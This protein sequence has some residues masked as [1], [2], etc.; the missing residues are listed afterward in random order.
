MTCCSSLLLLLQRSV[1][2]AQTSLPTVIR[3]NGPGGRGFIQHRFLS[4]VVRD[5]R[6]DSIFEKLSVLRSSTTHFCTKAPTEDE[7]PP[8]PDYQSD[9]D[10]QRKEV[11]IIQ[12]KGIPWSCTPQD[13]LQFFSECRIRDGLKGIHLTTDRS[14]R[15]SGRAFIEVE[16]ED[17]VSKAL[18][19]HRQYLGPRYVEVYEVTNNDAEAILNNA[20]EQ[21][22]SSDCVVRLRGLPYSSSEADI[23][24]FFSGMQKCVLSSMLFKPI[25]FNNLLITNVNYLFCT[26]GL[27]IAQNGITIVS[28]NKGRNSGVAYV[29][30]TSQEAFEEA[31]RRNRDMIGNRYIEVF[32]SRRD[33]IRTGWRKSSNSSLP[34]HTFSSAPRRTKSMTNNSQANE[35]HLTSSLPSHYVHMRGLPFS[36]S[37]EDIVKF[38][39]PLV[40]SK[41][42]IEFGPSGRPSGEADVYFSCHQQAVEAMSRDRMH[43]GDRYIE[44]F[45]NSEPNSERR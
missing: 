17:D 22:P 39:S 30:F 14:G 37:G 33:E 3:A 21:G 19:K 23:I 6:V 32:P 16:H 7:Y 27:D 2:I 15:P 45:L 24:D 42:L 8:L 4:S 11:Y 12:V 9:S 18:E 5:V 13:L 25:Y 38:F 29:E 10:L 41:M 1:R 44:L 20:A 28:D 31:L 43:I 35:S 36:V 40:V 26:L 34:Q